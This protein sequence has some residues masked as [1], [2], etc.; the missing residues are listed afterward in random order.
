MGFF[1]AFRDNGGP[2]HYGP[3]YTPVTAD[4]L[5]VGLL[6]GFSLILFSTIVVL[7]GIKGKQVCCVVCL[8]FWRDVQLTAVF[9]LLQSLLAFVKVFLTLYIGAVIVGE[10]PHC[11]SQLVMQC[12]FIQICR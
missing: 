3:Q 10:F 5:V 8:W 12:S 1:N 4:V 2:T 11:G 9:L 6:V 7:P